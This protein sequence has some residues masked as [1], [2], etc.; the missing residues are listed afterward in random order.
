ML[1]HT[2][3]PCKDNKREKIRKTWQTGLA[4]EHGI[5][6]VLIK[7]NDQKSMQNA[8]SINKCDTL[9]FMNKSLVKDLSGRGTERRAREDTYYIAWY[10]NKERAKATLIL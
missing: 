10:V 9:N 4:V 8:Y 3:V 2:F 7:N 5:H 6:Q 1:N